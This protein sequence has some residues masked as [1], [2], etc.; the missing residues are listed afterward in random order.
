[1]VQN[2]RSRLILDATYIRR[3]L[4]WNR[5][6]G[7]SYFVRVLSKTWTSSYKWFRVLNK[8]WTISAHACHMRNDN[9]KAS[10]CWPVTRLT[11]CFAVNQ[12]IAFFRLVS[13]FSCILRM[14]RQV[15]EFSLTARSSQEKRTSQSGKN[16][17][18]EVFSSLKWRHAFVFCYSAPFWILLTALLVANSHV[19]EAVSKIRREPFIR[20]VRVLCKTRTYKWYSSRLM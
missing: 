9:N 20:E 12:S 13:D 15:S 2:K 17:F 7:C 19:N 16:I 10:F 11:K 8:T 6:F 4:S 3:V 5:T 14:Q 1:M 18:E